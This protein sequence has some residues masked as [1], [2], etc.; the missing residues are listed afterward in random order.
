MRRVPLADFPAG[1]Q[2]GIFLHEVLED[3]DFA[4]G[5]TPEGRTALRERLDELLPRHGLDATL[6]A[7]PLTEHLSA[8]LTTPLG[9]PLGGSSLADIQRTER[10]DE[11]RFDL[12]VRGGRSWRAGVD[13]ALSGT[14]LLNALGAAGPR[15]ALRADY[16]AQLAALPV[17]DLAGFLTGSIDLVF[18][19]QVNGQNK[20]FIADY[21][22]NHL[23][24]TVA[25]YAPSALRDAMEGHHYPLQAHLYTLAL[26]R[27]LR[28]RVPDYDYERDVGGVYYLFLRGMTGE[29]APTPAPP[30]CFFDRPPLAV[31][32]ALDT[33]FASSPQ[34]AS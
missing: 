16:L 22:S 18:R 12:P 13:D 1:A 6:W 29:Q 19:Q 7:E 32:Q 31:V 30:G 27:L 11:L 23:G 24:D 34:E 9:G 33:L 10:F 14:A 2:P 4:W 20:W 17:G 21:K 5:R 3:T 26:H 15:D 8:V 28:W 25:G